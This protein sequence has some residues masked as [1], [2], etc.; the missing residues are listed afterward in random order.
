MYLEAAQNIRSQILEEVSLDRAS[1]PVKLDPHHL[2]ARRPLTERLGIPQTSSKD[3]LKIFNIDDL[4]ISGISPPTR[5][6]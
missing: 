1:P 5:T 3:K 2:L 4:S 6:G